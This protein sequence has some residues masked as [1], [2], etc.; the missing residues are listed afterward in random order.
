MTF[1]EKSN[2]VVL[3]VGVPTLLPPD[4]RPALGR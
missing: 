4:G 3:V 2:W 1:L